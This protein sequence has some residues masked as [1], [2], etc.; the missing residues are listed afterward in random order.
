MTTHCDLCG[1]PTA[2]LAIQGERSS[3]Y[4]CQ[5]CGHT[6]ERDNLPGETS[7]FKTAARL[8]FINLAPAAGLPGNF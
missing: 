2:V 5:L 3:Q 4:V 8:Q 6:F 7:D 1:Q